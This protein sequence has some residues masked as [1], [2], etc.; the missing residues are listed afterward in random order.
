[1]VARSMK[2]PEDKGKPLRDRT[3]EVVGS[4]PASP[5]KKGKED[6]RCRKS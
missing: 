5:L 2:K 3:G 6:D 1:M 4:I